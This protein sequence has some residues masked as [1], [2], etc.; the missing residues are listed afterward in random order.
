[1]K[2]EEFAFGRPAPELPVA[3]VEL[4]QRYCRQ[5]P[6]KEAVGFAPVTVE[7]PDGNRFHFH[8][9]RQGVV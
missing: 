2:R 6:R 5:A 7:D 1:V 3:D 9:D 4:A 8:C